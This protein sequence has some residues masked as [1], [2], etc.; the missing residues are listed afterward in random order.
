V[1]PFEIMKGGIFTDFGLDSMEKMTLSWV[2]CCQA[3]CIT[4]GESKLGH[5]TT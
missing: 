5:R 4:R 1:I 2:G 3:A